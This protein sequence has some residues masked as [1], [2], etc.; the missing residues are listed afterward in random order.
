MLGEMWIINDEDPEKI[1]QGFETCVTLKKL[2]RENGSYWMSMKA[3]NQVIRCYNHWLMP[4]IK[5]R[6]G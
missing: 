1:D 5:K 4:T 2:L 3:S 6:I